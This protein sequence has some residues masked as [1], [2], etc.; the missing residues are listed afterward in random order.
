[1]YSVFSAGSGRFWTSP[2]TTFAT[3]SSS[4]S[5]KELVTR[6]IVPL[7]GNSTPELSLTECGV[8]LIKV[9]IAGFLSLGFVFFGIFAMFFIK[10]IL[11]QFSAFQPQKPERGKLI[12]TRFSA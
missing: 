1:M 11:Y 12:Q 5:V 2:K 10:G 9:F 3:P 8:R 4:K 7:A 6:A